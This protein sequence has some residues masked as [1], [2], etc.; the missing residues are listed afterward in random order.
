MSVKVSSK[1]QVVIPEEVREAL[2][3]QPGLEVDVIAKGGIA[4]IV[5]VKQLSVLRD[6][7][8]KYGKVNTKD[9]RDKKDR[10]I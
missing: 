5:P 2:N 9:L 4:Y 6:T 8:K 1:Y 10:K 7:V 3:I